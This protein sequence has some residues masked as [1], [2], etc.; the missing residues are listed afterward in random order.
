MP[1]LSNER[2]VVNLHLD[3]LFGWL[4]TDWIDGRLQ[5][6][7]SGQFRAASIWS[8]VSLATWRHLDGRSSQC[9]AQLWPQSNYRLG[10]DAITDCTNRVMIGAIDYRWSGWQAKWIN[11]WMRRCEGAANSSSPT[12]QSNQNFT[13]GLESN[14][15]NKVCL[16]DEAV[17]SRL[18]VKE[19]NIYDGNETTNQPPSSID[20]ISSCGDK[21]GQWEPW[22]RSSDNN[23]N[24]DNNNSNNNNQ[25]IW[26]E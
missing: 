15:A 22:N 17:S 7:Q 3:G 4:I 19:L 16:L 6:R 14:L 9:L 12:W 1:S 21:E 11:W 20:M 13:I 25:R 26:N 10:L 24:D 18:P 23:N 5:L 8:P 2:R